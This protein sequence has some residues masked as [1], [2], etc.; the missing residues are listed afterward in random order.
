MV[1]ACWCETRRARML[2]RDMRTHKCERWYTTHT[3][4]GPRQVSTHGPTGSGRMSPPRYVGTPLTRV[5]APWGAQ[6]KTLLQRSHAATP[7][8]RHTS[9]T[10]RGRMESPTESPQL[11]RSLGGLHQRYEWLRLTP[12]A[13]ASGHGDIAP[14]HEFDASQS[15]QCTARRQYELRCELQGWR[16][17]LCTVLH[18][19]LHVY[20]AVHNGGFQTAINQKARL[21]ELC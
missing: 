4:R 18:P 3:R 2:A 20:S 1:V 9:H 21:R 7:Q 15:G 6:P 16:I 8:Y 11:P 5:V 14:P 19:G 12:P 17:I 10:F 13:N